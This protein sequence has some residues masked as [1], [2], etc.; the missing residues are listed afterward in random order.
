MH[1]YI[2][3]HPD[4]ATGVAARVVPYLDA[5][6]RSPEKADGLDTLITRTAQEV[7]CG[8]TE[9]EASDERAYLRWIKVTVGDSKVGTG[10][11][12]MVADKN[13]SLHYAPLHDL[14]ELQLRHRDWIALHQARLEQALILTPELEHQRQRNRGLDL[15]GR[16]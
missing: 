8:N 1:W 6:P 7:A 14:V 4:A 9:E 5:F 2:E 12:V 3:T 13:G 10:G 11:L 15:G 16:G